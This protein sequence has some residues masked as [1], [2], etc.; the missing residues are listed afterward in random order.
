VCAGFES[1]DALLFQ[2]PVDE[3]LDVLLRLE[4]RIG[5]DTYLRATV[6]AEARR[7]LAGAEGPGTP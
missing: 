5:F 2:E 4:G 1:L 3:R 6:F 7:R